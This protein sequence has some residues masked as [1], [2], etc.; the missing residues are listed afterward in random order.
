MPPPAAAAADGTAASQKIVAFAYA[1]ELD[2]ISI[3]LA[4][5]E[6]LLLHTDSQEV[7]EVGTI[8]GGVAAVSW[9]PDGE[10]VVVAST[11][12]NLLLMTKVC[13]GSCVCSAPAPP[14]RAS[15]R[16]CMDAAQA[17]FWG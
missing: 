14:A 16:G 13:A 4:S 11:T 5:G 3:A 17:S 1:L 15:S 2:A 12:G 8:Q 10:L 6:L 9:S 7:Q